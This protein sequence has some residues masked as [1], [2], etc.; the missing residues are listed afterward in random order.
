MKIAA[1]IAALTL[2]ACADSPEPVRGDLA[3]F[4]G[5]WGPSMH[6]TAAAGTRCDRPWGLVAVRAKVDR[7]VLTWL[8]GTNPATVGPTLAT[9]RGDVLDGCLS[10]P[11]GLD[12]DLAHDAY[13]LCPVDGATPREIRGEIVWGR[14]TVGECHCDTTLREQ[15]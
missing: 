14:G 10:V 1:L 5:E 15:P 11:A 7:A 4:D 12:G 13:D 3:T 6:C 2:A 8:D 9:H